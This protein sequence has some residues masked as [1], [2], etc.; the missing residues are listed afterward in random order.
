[1]HHPGLKER[2]KYHIAT[3]SER[4]KNN[5]RRTPFY[6]DLIERGTEAEILVCLL[7]ALSAVCWRKFQGVVYAIKISII[8]DWFG[9]LEFLQL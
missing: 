9:W 8:G 4:N 7:S 1:L 3:E 5:N 6:D 2:L